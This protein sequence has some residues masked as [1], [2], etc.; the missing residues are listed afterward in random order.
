[1]QLASRGLAR[2]DLAQQQAYVHH[3]YRLSTITLQH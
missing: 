1:M 2:P 3:R